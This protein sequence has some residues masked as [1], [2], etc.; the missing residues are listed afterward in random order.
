LTARRLFWA[1]LKSASSVPPDAW[2]KMPLTVSVPKGAAL[3]PA[4][5]VPLVFVTLPLTVPVPASVPPVSVSGEFRVP[6]A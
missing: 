3:L 2:L 6:S 5:T 1:L 4:L